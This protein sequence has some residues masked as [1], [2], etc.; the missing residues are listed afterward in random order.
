MV[1]DSE[2]LLS[3]VLGPVRRLKLIVQFL[4][5]FACYLREDN[6]NFLALDH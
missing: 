4:F 5:Q 2:R 6:R 3:A 1:D